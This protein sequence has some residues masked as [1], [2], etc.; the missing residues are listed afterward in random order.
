MRKQPSSPKVFSTLHRWR[1]PNS[2]KEETSEIIHSITFTG[3]R[4]CGSLDSPRRKKKNLPETA[5]HGQFHYNRV[6]VT[7]CFLKLVLLKD[8]SS[9]YGYIAKYPKQNSL[10]H[11]K[12][13]ELKW[14]W[15]YQGPWPYEIRRI[16]QSVP[17]RIEIFERR[18][19]KLTELTYLSI[20]SLKCSSE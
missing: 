15:H 14:T 3:Q 20:Q 10:L 9:V 6:P 13:I 18:Q 2:V 11:S 12:L 19:D 5:M 8:Q 17:L 1:R 7:S 16:T 4:Q